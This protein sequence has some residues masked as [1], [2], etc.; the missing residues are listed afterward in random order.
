MTAWPPTTPVRRHPRLWVENLWLLESREPLAVVR[1][2][3]FHPGLNIVW[4]REPETTVGSGY[5]SAGHGV[6]KTSLCLL[7]RYCLGDEAQSIAALRD[8]ALAGFPKGSV[9]AKVHVDGVSWLICR[10]YADRVASAAGRGEEL[11]D[12]LAGEL[13][14]DWGEF[15]SALSA[16]FIETLPAVTL[17]GSKQPLEWRHLLAWCIRDQKTRFDHFF[18]WRDG[19][20]LGFRRP[21]QDPPRFVQTVLGLIDTDLDWLL[22][23]VEACEED[24]QAIEVQRTEAATSL[25]QA[26]AFQRRQL[27]RL[28]KAE[29][30]LPV[31]EAITGPSLQSLLNQALEAADREETALMREIETAEIAQGELSLNRA[32]A[33]HE[34]HVSGIERAR[35]QSLLDANQLEYERL[36]TE[37][38][39]L[40]NLQGR[41]QHGDVEFSECNY[42]LNRRNNPSLP[43]RMDIREAEANKPAR[44]AALLQATKYDEAAT[45]RLREADF[46]YIEANAVLHRLGNRLA[47]LKV[48]RDY[49]QLVWEELSTSVE[50]RASEA[51][52][53][54]PFAEER[55]AIEQKLATAKSAV[56]S[57]AQ[58]QLA[59]TEALKSLTCVLVSRLLGDAGYGRFVP[60]SDD[61]PFELALGGEAYQVL[62]VLLGDLTCLLDAALASE[63]HHPGFLVHDCPREADM[64][65][66]LYREY[67]LAA[68]EAA[69]ALALEN[70]VP[71]QY[72]VTTTSAPP[73]SL[74]SAGYVVLEL[75]PGADEHLLFK[76][77]LQ[78]Q[79]F[80]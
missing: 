40:E 71:F 16:A 17:P 26:E 72:I 13:T 78:P 6:G 44:E 69:E 60:D 36:S 20:G 48:H 45:A 39:R 65:E 77:R 53:A 67:L 33:R 74:Q 8:K 68:A 63:S 55:A 29:P 59:R 34:A 10:P 11:E 35:S 1:Q 70:E 76:R 21:R 15:S 51:T 54:Q 7:L 22:R 61:H 14:G 4:A 32:A 49:M 24:I 31:F 30:G 9:A 19:D 64:S 46:R 3:D 38:Q 47:T 43:W 52:L 12:L 56:H 37:L 28:L 25:A 41:C 50:K 80:E 5:S 75:F 23:E 66:H 73:R 62:E 42:I 18:H 57:K 79:L 2:I 58:G 27:E